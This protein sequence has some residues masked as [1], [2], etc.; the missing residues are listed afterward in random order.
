MLRLKG[1]AQ[2][3]QQVRQRSQAF[4]GFAGELQ[5][6][7]REAG[8]ILRQLRRPSPLQRQAKVVNSARLAARLTSPHGARQRACRLGRRS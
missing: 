6:Q 3:T 5:E 2:E 7:L 4:A 1:L 8:D